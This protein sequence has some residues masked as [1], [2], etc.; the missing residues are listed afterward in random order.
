LI[1]IESSSRQDQQTI[2]RQ[3]L[4]REGYKCVYTGIFDR[5]SVEKKKVSL[6]Q[7]AK[8]GGTECAHILPFAL[9]NFQENDALA[10]ENKAIIWFTLHRYFPALKPKISSGSINQL[11]NVATMFR[12]VHDLFGDFKLSFR[13]QENVP[14][15]LFSFF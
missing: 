14:V 15:S 8:Y 10:N 2:K 9:G 13:P 6:P 7:G 3:A 1:S 4:R 12:E 5:H 11:G